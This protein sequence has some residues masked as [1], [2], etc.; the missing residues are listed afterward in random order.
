MSIQPPSLAVDE[1]LNI[2]KSYSCIEIKT[3]E[4]QVEREQLQQ[5]LRL[6]TRLSESE[7][8]GVCADNAKQGFAALD[9]YLKAL[10]YEYQTNPESIPNQNEP[11]YIKFNTQKMSHYL[12]AYPGTYRGVLVSCQSDKDKLSGTYGHFPLD[13]FL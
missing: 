7:N 2:L 8:F 5:A 9:S 3:V 11:V 12:D 10:G 6:V 4:S 1:A 13:L